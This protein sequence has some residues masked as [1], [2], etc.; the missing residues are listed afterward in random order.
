VKKKTAYKDLHILPWLVAETVAERPYTG[1][2]YSRGPLRQSQID[3]V[4]TLRVKLT[5]EGIKEFGE[6]VDKR[7]ELAYA[8][9]AS[10]FM[11][12]VEAKDNS[13]RDQLYMWVTHWL[14]A[15]LFR[16]EGE[17]SH[18]SLRKAPKFNPKS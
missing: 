2:E 15:F 5:A 14:V 10:W 1:Q 11:A 17:K 3:E 13:G 9:K 7:C 16:K 6:Y 12:I 18:E 8:A 4:E